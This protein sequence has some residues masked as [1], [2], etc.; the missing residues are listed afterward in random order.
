MKPEAKYYNQHS[1]LFFNTTVHVDMSSLYA[2][3]LE[4]LHPG[5][6]ILDAGCGSGR[7]A[8]YFQRNGYNVTAFDASSE[9]VRLSTEYTGLPVRLLCFEDMDY[10]EEYDAV[11][12]C[13]SLLHIERAVLPDVLERVRRALKSPGLLYTSFKYGNNDLQKDGR[14]FT[15]YIEDTIRPLLEK[16]GF[17]EIRIWSSGDLR[18]GRQSEQ[19]LNTLYRKP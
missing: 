3:F 18:P 19:W 1:Q 9:M 15:C 10:N 6:S 14:H 2:P 12:A 16:A 4:L 11:W 13:A 17:T 8:L 5:A 7:D